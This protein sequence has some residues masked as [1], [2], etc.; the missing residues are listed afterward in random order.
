MHGTPSADAWKKPKAYY[1]T[2][3]N[4]KMK[5][6][7]PP[8]TPKNAKDLAKFAQNADLPSGNPHK[9]QVNNSSN[10]TASNITIHQ[11]FKTDMTLN[12]VSSPIDAANAVKRQQENS[13]AFMA[14][15]AMNPLVG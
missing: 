2:T 10:T 3:P 7:T 5:E 1:I 4:S 9:P 14:R 12:G 13:L 8:I 6:A 15:N 11:S